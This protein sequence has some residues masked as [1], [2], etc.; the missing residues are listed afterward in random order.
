MKTHLISY[1]LDKPGQDYT[2]IIA[3]LKELGAVKV[4]YSEWVL[5]HTASAAEIRDD[6]QRFIDASDM[7]LVVV[8]TGEAAWTKLMI[9]DNAFKQSIGAAA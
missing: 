1:D 4:L 5:R 9:S 3:R 7:L 2:G 6:L 8:L